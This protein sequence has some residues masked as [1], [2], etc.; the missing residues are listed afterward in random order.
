[1]TVQ[2]TANFVDYV[3]N[4]VALIFPFTFRV[5]D[6]AWL[7]VDFVDDFSTF[8][9]NLDQDLN[10][11]GTVVHTVAPPSPGMGGP[12]SFRVT[13][14][15][16]QTQNLN[17]TRYDP[18]DSESHE[19]ALDKLTMQ[20]QDLEQTFANL[21]AT[22]AAPN[23]TLRFGLTGYLEFGP[24]MDEYFF[25]VIDGL[26]GQ[27][28]VTDGAG[29]LD[30]GSVGSG[31]LIGSIDGS[32]LRFNLGSGDFVEFLNYLFPS[33]DG[34]VDQV[35]ITDGVGVLSFEHLSAL[36]FGVD[37]TIRASNFLAADIGMGA[38]VRTNIG[39]FE[40][41]G[42]NVL[43]LRVQNADL[44][45]GLSNVGE[46]IIHDEVTPRTYSLNDISATKVGSMWAIINDAGAG[47]ILFQAGAGCIITFWNGATWVTSL[48]AG[49][50]VAGEGH[51]T[52]YK[53]T[54]FEYYLSG[55]NLV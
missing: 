1:M 33:A 5:N 17:Y 42:M 4:D 46:M 8:T 55:P 41:V 3:G 7:S 21:I 31:G 20:I 15:T 6:V 24:N 28:M 40:P 27:V 16:P 9:L 47:D 26:A 39:T 18:F 22:G 19:D 51:F 37:E 2:N 32:T 36:F 34:L 23:S 50:V 44:I 43:P 12:A 49:F 11:G 53:R 48:V 35:L 10:P 30:W 25:P 38:E 29:Q 52:I 14:S 13:R 45:I 54:D